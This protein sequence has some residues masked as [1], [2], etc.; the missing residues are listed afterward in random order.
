[1]ISLF[2]KNI[3]S[4]V[5]FTG[6]NQFWKLISGLVTMV[7]IPLFLTKETQGYWFTIMSLAA[8]VMLAD[9]GFSTI[10]TQFTAHEFSFLSLDD[11]EIAG[12]EQHLNR[13]ATF[14]VFSAKWALGILLI[15]FPIISVIGYL[16]LSQENGAVK[17]VLPWFLYLLGAALTFFNN[18]QLCFFEGCNLVAPIQRI[19]VGISIITFI[20][21]WLV[22]S[23]IYPCTHFRYPCLSALSLDRILYGEGSGITYV[24]F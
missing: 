1:M 24:H 22:L 7:L 15:A 6:L 21:M 8:L 2:K 12:S 13:L 10:I 11:H 20:L 17:W 19:R 3:D 4:A 14:F 5:L 23:L 9:L 18:S 16:V